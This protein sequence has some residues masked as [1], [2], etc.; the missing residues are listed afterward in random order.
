M[1]SRNPRSSFNRTFNNEH[2]RRSDRHYDRNYD[3][4]YGSERDFD[5]RVPFLQN[6]IRNRGLD[7][8]PQDDKA[9]CGATMAKKRF[10]PII[11]SAIFLL[12]SVV[13]LIIDL[14]GSR[15]LYVLFIL[16]AVFA[17]ISAFSSYR[18]YSAFTSGKFD[19]YG[20][21]IMHVGISRERK[22]ASTNRSD[23][24]KRGSRQDEYIEHPYAI[25]NGITI[26][27][28]KSVYQS[29]GRHI[30][31]YYYV[32]RIKRFSSRNDEYYFLKADPSLENRRTGSCDPRS[33]R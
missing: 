17:G 3:R 32:L 21:A 16:L 1:S 26:P 28:S 4:R 5:E 25:V 24:A 29:L 13:L 7:I 27:V 14:L 31:D 12:I 2:D 33:N 22:P 9:Q 11:V 6:D 10:T 30:N 20:G 8:I 23:S 18:T 15:S 19:M